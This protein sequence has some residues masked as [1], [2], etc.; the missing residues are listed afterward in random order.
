MKSPTE[1]VILYCDAYLK[2]RKGQPRGLAVK[3][4][5]SDVGGP[6]SD[7]G[8]A[9]RHHFSVHPEAESHIK[10]LEGCATM[11]YNYLLGLWG[12]K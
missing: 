11:T 5:R 3:C 10:Q 2:Q 4:T 7:P 12:G 6:G 1:Y 9:P 8:R